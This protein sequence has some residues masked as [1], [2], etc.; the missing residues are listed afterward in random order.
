[1]I[2][3]L[4]MLVVQQRHATYHTLSAPPGKGA[5]LVV[6]F[7]PH[8]SEAQL[9]QLVRANDAHIVGGPTETGAYLIRVPDDKAI[10]ARKMLHDSAEVTMAENLE[11]GAE[12]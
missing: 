2:L 5:L 12:P 4:G 3:A 6:V 9:R 11:T 1:V 10:A 7:D 8:I